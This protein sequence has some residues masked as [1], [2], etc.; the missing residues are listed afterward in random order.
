[1]PRALWKGAISFSLVHIPVQLFSATRSHELD[2]DMLDKRDFSP[3]GYKRVNKATG[4]TVEWGDIVKGYQYQKGEYVVLTE[5]DF[6]KANV[7]ATRTIDIHAFVEREAVAPYY[8]D[9]P[10][11]LLPDRSG[12]KVY[13][14]L[15]DALAKSQRLAIASVVIRTRQHLCALYPVEDMIVLDTLRYAS[16]I[17]EVPKVKASGSR[18]A[19]GASAREVQMA[20][21]L[22]DE[23]SEPWKPA[24][25][26]DTYREDLMKR[27]QEKIESDETHALT[28]VRAPRAAAGGKVVDLMG[29]L[30]ESLEQTKQ[31]Q[32]KQPAEGT[33]RRSTYAR[34]RASRTRGRRRA[35]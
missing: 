18:R 5:G 1:M 32:T 6:R 19:P 34:R 8:F 27:I 23:L 21:K 25:Y 9:T 2:L 35:A 10:Y 26:H 33:R 4:K 17:A 15:R 28:P 3:V 31:P 20:L 14:L 11:Y 7:E 16:E 29:L 24:R 22:I 13:A 12:G 30:K